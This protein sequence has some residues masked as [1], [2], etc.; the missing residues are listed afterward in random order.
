MQMG[1]LPGLLLSLY[2]RFAQYLRGLEAF[3]INYLTG[4]SRKGLRNTLS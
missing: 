2:E 1:E 4:I 3:F